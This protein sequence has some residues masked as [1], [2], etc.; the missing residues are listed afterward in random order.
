MN[1]FFEDE[2]KTTREEDKDLFGRIIIY[3]VGVKTDR[4]YDLY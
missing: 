1:Y 3:L 4:K 2:G